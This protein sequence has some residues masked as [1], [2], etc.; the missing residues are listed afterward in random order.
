MMNYK[1]EV[2]RLLDTLDDIMVFKF[3]YDFLVTVKAA[4][5]RGR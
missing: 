4:G 3:I 5:V 2:Y 1:T